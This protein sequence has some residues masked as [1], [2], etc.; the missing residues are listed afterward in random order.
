MRIY[1]V[2]TLSLEL[3]KTFDRFW[4][5]IAI[6]GEVAQ[7]N[8]PRSGHCYFQ[9]REGDA[10]L[11][12]ILW[13]NDWER[14]TYRPNIGDRV[15]CR[16]KVGLFGGKVQIYAHTI[17]PAGD[18]WMAKQIQ[19]RIERLRQ[20]GLLDPQRKRPLPRFPRIVGVATSADGAAIADFLRVSGERFPATRILIS[21]CSVQ[22]PQA[23]ASVV[24]ALDLLEEHGGCEVIVVTRGGGSKEDLMA[25]MDEGLARRIAACKVPVVSA[26]GHAIDTTL[27]DLVADVVVPTPTAAAVEVLPDGHA[28]AAHVDQG[29]GRL[30]RGMQRLLRRRRERLAGLQ[31]RLRHPSA[32][33]V[34]T[35]L[36]LERLQ[37]RMHRSTA[38]LVQQ[39]QN[40]VRAAEGRLN[41]LSP[42]RVLGRGYALVRDP[43]GTVIHDT[44]QVAAGDPLTV[45]VGNGSFHVQVQ[46]DPGVDSAP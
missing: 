7:I 37:T 13:R 2:K 9:L 4:P 14:S 40:Q 31:G 10:V 32:Q 19:E 20:D 23:P 38:A 46:A 39:R 22:G 45:R 34:R 16:G 41:A 17:A 8:L 44:S 29:A 43:D 24:R 36:A 3:A 30:D 35:R 18:G 1:T 27:S 28:L 15:Q 11:G 25:F 42:L 12:G 33:L 6:E 5:R 26:V 21:P